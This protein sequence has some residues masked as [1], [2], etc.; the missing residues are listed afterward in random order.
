MA[1]D[2]IKEILVD[3][4]SI[5]AATIKPESKVI[6]DLGADS[7]AVM[8]VVMG[9]EDEFGIEVPEEEI[10]NMVTVKDIVDYVEKNK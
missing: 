2:K 9:I 1:L 7:L 10:K 6:D 3:E 4:L 5:D 8:Q